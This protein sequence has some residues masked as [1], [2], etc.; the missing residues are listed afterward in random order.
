MKKWVVIVAIILL[1]GT[2][3]GTIG[4]ATS[5]SDLLRG[6]SYKKSRD[7]PE[8]GDVIVDW[9]MNSGKLM[10]PRYNSCEIVD[11]ADSSKALRQY[12]PEDT[13][14]DTYHAIFASYLD[15]DYDSPDQEGSIVFDSSV[16]WIE[17]DL[18]KSDLAW[19]T[20]YKLEFKGHGNVPADW[21]WMLN[22]DGSIRTREG[23]TFAQ[24][25]LLRWT[26]IGVR[27]DMENDTFD[28]YVNGEH[29]TSC[30]FEYDSDDIVKFSTHGPVNQNGVSK[31]ILMD[32]LKIML[33]K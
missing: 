4:V 29:V 17:M 20:G 13:T 10:T 9:N 21:V 22:E 7:W 6:T 3:A 2:V 23:K 26:T 32:N 28:Y 1:F 24:L 14:Q 5:A 16:F 12:T 31:A 19:Y 8:D 27:I 18:R 11:L 15:P 30:E 25:S 33:D